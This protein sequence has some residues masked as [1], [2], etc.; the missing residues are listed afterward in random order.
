MIK[1]Q[2][3]FKGEGSK[4]KKNLKKFFFKLSI[5][6]A[7]CK[8]CTCFKLKRKNNNYYLML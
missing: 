1:A 3:K 5:V 8:S 7:F 6:L 2:R 4:F